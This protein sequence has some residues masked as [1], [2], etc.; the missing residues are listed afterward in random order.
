MKCEK[1]NILEELLQEKNEV[2]NKL[3]LAMEDEQLFH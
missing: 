2:M 3:E 1:T